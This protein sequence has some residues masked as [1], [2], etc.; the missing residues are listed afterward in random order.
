MHKSDG[1]E[2]VDVRECR[3]H[4]VGSL[5]AARNKPICVTS[6]DPISAVQTLTLQRDAAAA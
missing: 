4:R 3:L 6:N 5:A 2:G 1:V